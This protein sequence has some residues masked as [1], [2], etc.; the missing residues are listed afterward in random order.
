MKI[1]KFRL[2]PGDMAEAENIE[3]A[4]DELPE[5]EKILRAAAD[6]YREAHHPPV[7]VP[8]KPRLD[9]L[10]PILNDMFETCKDPQIPGWLKERIENWRNQIN[11]K[12]MVK[13]I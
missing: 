8:A 13:G 10:I 6:M 1:A 5:F 9:L 2:G 12:L 3:L 4:L 11:D 7:V